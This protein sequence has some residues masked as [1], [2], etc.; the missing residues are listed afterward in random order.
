M[1]IN[2]DNINKNTH[3]TTIFCNLTNLLC[4]YVKECL[5]PLWAAT[6]SIACVIVIKQMHI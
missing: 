4:D 2:D 6:G 5:C 3:K 1:G